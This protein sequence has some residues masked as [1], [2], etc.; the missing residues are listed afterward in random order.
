VIIA[1]SL[2]LGA[3]FLLSG[4]LK[5]SAPRQWLSQSADL[6]VPRVVA[7]VV[8]FAESIVGALLVAQFERRVVALAAAALLVGFT[9]L[10]VMRLAQGSRPPCACFGALTTKPIGWSNVVRNGALLALAAFV[11]GWAG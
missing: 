10:L 2:V 8:P 7:A 9:I 4:I 11:A 6:G 5:M 1:A 3:V